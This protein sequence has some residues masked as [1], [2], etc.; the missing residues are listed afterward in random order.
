MDIF[1]SF[2]LILAF[3]VAIYAFVAGIVGIVTRRPLLSKSARHAGM[4]V[5]GLITLAVACLEYF[6]FTDN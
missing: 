6:F 2:A 1:G 5:C 4:A 3:L